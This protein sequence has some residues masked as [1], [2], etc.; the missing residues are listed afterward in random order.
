MSWRLAGRSSWPSWRTSARAPSTPSSLVV[1]WRS[2]SPRRPRRRLRERRGP[3]SEAGP[4]PSRWPSPFSIDG[5]TVAFNAA[6]GR[7]LGS[8]IVERRWLRLRVVC[9]RLRRLNRCDGVR[10]GRRR[11]MHRALENVGHIRRR[12]HDRLGI[13]RGL[14]SHGLAACALRLGLD[15]I[16]RRSRGSHGRLGHRCRSRATSPR[17]GRNGIAVR[18]LRIG[19]GKSLS[20]EFM[21]ARRVGG[22][23]FLGG[24]AAAW[25]AGSA[26]GKGVSSWSAT[27]CSGRGLDPAHE[28]TRLGHFAHPPQYVDDPCLLRGGGP[29]DRA[30]QQQVRPD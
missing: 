19:R 4:S 8:R 3:S 13:R 12:H 28:P 30:S 5:Q 15:R 24:G 1:P 16:G 17:L 21:L 9:C 20:C 14:D 23:R 7:G 2:R 11:G 6:D 10:G 27:R 29:V 22:L 18:R 25:A 26:A